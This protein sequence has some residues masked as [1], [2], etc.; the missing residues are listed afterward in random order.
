MM[1]INLCTSGL[2][3][4][5]VFFSIEVVSTQN[6]VTFSNDSVKFSVV[7]SENINRAIKSICAIKSVII[8][9]TGQSRN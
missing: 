9:E 6:F 7:N 1:Q 8:Q 2:H 4:R 5:T 3:V